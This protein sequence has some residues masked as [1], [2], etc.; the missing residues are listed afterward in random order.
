M[1]E[2][3]FRGIWLLAAL[4]AALGLLASG[5]CAGGRRVRSSVPI[6]GPELVDGS[7]PMIDVSNW[8]GSVRILAKENYDKASVTAKLYRAS[9]KDV[10]RSG[11]SD[12][13]TVT[14]ESLVENGRP[15][16]RIRSSTTLPNPDRARARLIICV[17]DCDGVKVRN[18]GG[19]VELRHVAGAI[20][21]QNG[22]GSGPGGRIELWTAKPMTEPV[23]LTTNGGIVLYQIAPRS[24]GRFDM[25][26]VNG[27]AAMEA[28]GGDVRA[29]TTTYDRFV[30]TLNGGENPVT[31][32]SRNGSVWARVIENAGEYKPPRW[33]RGKITSIQPPR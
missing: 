5:G 6:S 28:Y 13:T 23:T 10:S 22:V 20:D 16:L 18:A 4:A 25:T 7:R 33:P 2:V 17:P 29:Q 19:I 31:L 24:T 14:A 26:A 3:N 12:A 11:L 21:V 27:Q 32:T 15:V 1:R 9:R 8:N 30:G